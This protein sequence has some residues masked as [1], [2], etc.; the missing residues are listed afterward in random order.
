VKT[1][2]RPRRLAIPLFGL[3]AAFGTLPLLGQP[4]PETPP[5]PGRPPQLPPIEHP[6]RRADSVLHRPIF[7]LA[8]CSSP[9]LVEQKFP[10]AGAEETRWRICWQDQ[11]K[12]GLVITS[13]HFRK[14]PNSPWVRLFWDARVAE[15][16]VPYH[17]NE[18]RFQDVS[19]FNFVLHDL[20]AA[21]C[22][23]AKG[24][25]LLGS[26]AKACQE[27]RDR[28]LAWKEHNLV[29]RGEE[30][31]LWGALHAVNYDYVMEWTFR[32]DGVVT[33]RLGAT[34][35]NYPVW[36]TVA[37]IHNPIWRLDIDLDGAAGDSAHLGIHN[38]NL[39]GPTATDNAVMILKETGLE[40][41]PT[42]FHTL[43]IHD[44]TLKNGKG[45][46][47]AYT[48]IPVRSGTARHQ[49]DFTKRDFWVTRYNGSELL[50]ADYYGSGSL[51][52][53]VS[54][55]ENVSNA[56]IVVW[57]MGSIHH[58][59]RDEDGECLHTVSGGGTVRVPDEQCDYRTPGPPPV[60][61]KGTALANWTGFV[62][63]PHNLFDRTP[64]YP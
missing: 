12:H 23:A 32:D 46:A 48:L 28:G 35:V 40:W 6:V 41:N 42:N 7:T 17:G 63:M 39:P 43:S 31:V 18:A 47:T 1:F 8:S 62:L 52:K 56:D 51:P 34:A 58:I 54:N 44:A 30:L 25:K 45:H 2:S 15:I 16:F 29:R 21:D 59:P 50:A 37:H 27:V 36:P 14:S 5:R 20:S 61:W 4:G 33:G 10:T 19:E 49:E 60:F 55:T 22:P 53:Y 57:Y 9:H 26:P 3:L 64:L 24:G 38:E 13:A 11:T